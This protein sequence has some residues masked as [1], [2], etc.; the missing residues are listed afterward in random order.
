MV[1]IEDQLALY[2]QH[3][4]NACGVSPDRDMGEQVKMAKAAGQTHYRRMGTSALARADK[5]REVLREAP[6]QIQQ[7][8]AVATVYYRKL[9]DRLLRRA[10]LYSAATARLSRAGTVLGLLASGAYRPVPKGG[11]GHRALLKDVHATVFHVSIE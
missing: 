8:A 10:N 11:L 6:T 3:D 4:A 9:G 5:L 1:A 2:R 7:R